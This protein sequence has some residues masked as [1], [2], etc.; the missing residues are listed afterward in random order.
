MRFKTFN[1][2]YQYHL[3]LYRDGIDSIIYYQKHP[4]GNHLVEKK[5]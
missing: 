4:D 2:A 5:D 3:E 1:E